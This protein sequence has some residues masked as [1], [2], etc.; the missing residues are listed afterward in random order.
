MSLWVDLSR[1][2]VCCRPLRGHEHPSVT[3]TRAQAPG[4]Q[5]SAWYS[6]ATPDHLWS[7]STRLML[8]LGPLFMLFLQPGKSRPYLTHSNAAQKSLPLWNP[9]GP[10][11]AGPHAYL[12]HWI[13]H[14]ILKWSLH[15][16]CPYQGRDLVIPG[17]NS[18]PGRW[19]ALN[20]WLNWTRISRIN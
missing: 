5:L 20:K 11:H 2:T 14:V 6:L 13:Y 1:Q 7:L 17:P 16:L 10:T 8:D 18:K 19:W 12:H 9:S 15:A 3:V 4:L